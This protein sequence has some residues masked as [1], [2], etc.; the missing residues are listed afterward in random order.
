MSHASGAGGGG[1]GGDGGT[2]RENMYTSTTPKEWRCAE[3][4]QS[5]AVV[6]HAQLL[7]LRAAYWK[8]QPTQPA[9]ARIGETHSAGVEG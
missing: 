2:C 1:E 5:T 8:Y 6:M 3:S 4:A 7:S 9:S